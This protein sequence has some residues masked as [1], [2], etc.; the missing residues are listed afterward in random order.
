MVQMSS[1]CSVH[2]V[3]VP[4]YAVCIFKIGA[5]LLV[6]HPSMFG[7]EPWDLYL[8]ILN[9]SIIYH[10]CHAKESKPA[11]ICSFNAPERFAAE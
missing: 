2:T 5:K 7:T 6:F 1:S 11:G 10:E 4:R 8:P 3:L 9:L